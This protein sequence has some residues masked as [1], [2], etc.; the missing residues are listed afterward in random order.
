MSDI[1]EGSTKHKIFVWIS[2]VT[3]IAGCIASLLTILLI[4][5]MKKKGEQLTSHVLLV[6]ILSYF[7]MFY[8][9]SFFFRVNSISYYCTMVFNTFQYF[10]GLSGSLISNWMSL[11]TF[12]IVVYRKVVNANDS[13]RLIL[14]SVTLPSFIVAFI[15]L[16]SSIPEHK[17]NELLLLIDQEVYYY[18]RLVLIG[19]N[20]FFC[21]AILYKVSLMSSKS[22]SGRVSPQEMA[23]RLL[24]RRMVL[25][26]IVQ[27]ISRSGL[28]WYEIA[29][30]YK[31]NSDNPTP[32][33]FAS[34][35]VVSII[36]PFASVAYLLI[37]L[38]MQP[39]AYQQFLCMILGRS[40][41]AVSATRKSSREVSN[42]HSRER[43]NSL[44]S[45]SIESA[46]VPSG[47]VRRPLWVEIDTATSG[48][49]YEDQDLL[50]M[51]EPLN[52]NVSEDPFRHY[53][54]NPIFRSTQDTA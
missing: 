44:Q 27:A 35:L 34:L 11:S 20:F 2:L 19:I 25:Y 18:L 17:E 32:I 36:T 49:M 37:F 51:I 45:I 5:R 42:Q 22:K 8:D 6:L 30:G 16:G 26:P 43:S 4:R 52:P 41:P 47:D 21:S 54:E 33:Q 1:F 53:S 48:H 14:C 10:F 29:Y 39:D 23:I 31:I 12:L 46:S 24:A 15:F 13:L 28:A 3:S 9:I 40:V 7:Q 38:M 50:S